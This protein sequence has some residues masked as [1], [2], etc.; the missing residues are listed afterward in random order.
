MDGVVACIFQ[1]GFY[2]LLEPSKAVGMGIFHSKCFLK[3]TME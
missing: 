3:K 1:V 2:L